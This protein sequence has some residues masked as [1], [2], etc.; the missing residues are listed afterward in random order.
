[1][2]SGASFG[3]ERR[4]GQKSDYD[5]VF[6]RPGYRIRKQ[7]FV[8][9]ARETSLT[10]SRLGVIVGK[11]CARSAVV[12]NRIKRI[13]RESFRTSDL[14]KAHLDIVIIAQP[15]AT[16]VSSGELF[17]TLGESWLHLSQ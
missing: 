3:P 2:Q 14:A 12:R 5:T 13:I 11:R 9:L 4:L 8:V 10:T 17:R 7:S 6:S 15:G 16:R 1:M